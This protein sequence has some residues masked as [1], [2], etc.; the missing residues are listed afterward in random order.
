MFNKPGFFAQIWLYFKRDFLSKIHDRQYLFI[1]LLEAPHQ[2][3]LSLGGQ[4]LALRFGSATLCDMA[5]AARVDGVLQV[6]LADERGWL[7]TFDLDETL[8]PDALGVMAMLR[9]LGLG[10]Q[11]LS[12]DR[13]DHVARLAWRVRIDQAFGGRSPQGKLEHVR[14]L[15][16]Q[17]HRVGMVGDGLND[18]PV[19]ACADLSITVGQAAPVAQSRADVV[20]PGGQL[21]A[22]SLFM[23]Q[24]RRTQ[25][26][27]RQNLLWSALYN[28][29][30]VPLAVAGW[31]PPWLAG[32]G[33]AA[34]SLAVVLN[35][36]RL[37][38]APRA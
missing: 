4:A 12:G 36:A 19:L 13:A 25:A 8:R 11:L 17:G 14:G 31:M 30:C 38:R 23:Q 1:N 37:A 22:V 3:S 28:A 29:V 6:H 32:L 7:A 10:L 33:M 26:V 2:G 16:A 21:G 27:V 18:G 35:A 9:S 20:V 34:S 5:D 15:Q 24:A